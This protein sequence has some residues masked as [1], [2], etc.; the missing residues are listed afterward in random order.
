MM[1]RNVERKIASIHMLITTISN[2]RVDE[3]TMRSF[4]NQAMVLW[5]ISDSEPVLMVITDE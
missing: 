1:K 2:A 5:P 3:N 4:L